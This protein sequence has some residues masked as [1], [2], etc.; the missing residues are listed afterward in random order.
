MATL[1]QFI[2]SKGDFI[3]TSFNKTEQLYQG[4]EEKIETLLKE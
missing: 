3:L 4:F 2:S 1:L